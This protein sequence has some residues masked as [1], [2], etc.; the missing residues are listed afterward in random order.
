MK[1]KKFKFEHVVLIIE[2]IIIILAGAFFIFYLSDQTFISEIG[3]QTVFMISIGITVVNTIFCL[4]SL[5]IAGKRREKTDLKIGTIIGSDIKEA[6]L[7]AKVG[8]VVVNEEGYVLWTSDLFTARQINIIGRNIYEWIPNLRECLEKKDDDILKI[9]FNGMD[10]QVKFLKSAGLFIFKDVTE[11]E[12]LDKYSKDQSLCLG[13]IVI[14]NYLEFTSGTDENNDTVNEVRMIINNYFKKFD[15]LLRQ[16]KNDSYVLICN[17]ASLKKLRDDNFSIIDEVRQVKAKEIVKPTLSIGIA[18]DYLDINRLSEMATNSI[19]IAMSRGGDQVVISRFG[20]DLEFFGGKSEATVNGSRVKL[21]VVS[22]SL[23]NLVETASNVVI[24]GH[25]EADMDAIGSCLGLKAFCDAKNKDVK[26]VYDSKLCERKTKQAVSSMFSREE[27]ANIFV[28]PKQAEDLVDKKTLLIVTDVSRPS[29]TMAPKLLE[30]TDKIVIIDHHRRAQEFIEN[31]ILFYIEPG[32][33]SSS[34]IVAQMAKYNT[35]SSEIKINSIFATFMLSG[36]FLDSLNFKSKTTGQGT[37][38]ASMILKDFGA[39]IK[40][41][42]DLLKDDFEEY[43]LINKIITNSTV[44]A[45]GIRICKCEN[46]EIVET[47]TIAKAANRALSFKGMSCSF[48]VG[49][50]AEKE[51]KICARSDGSINVQILMEL[52]GGGGHHSMAAASIEET[53][54]EKVV[55]QINEVL[56]N[57]LD[58]AKKKDKGE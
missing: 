23:L 2:T 42:D 33:S 35:S 7:F 44:P 56:E 46:D 39:D 50:V 49:K 1:Q 31:T 53:E 57:H 34:E 18:Y 51:I 5:L 41:A 12:A 58:E 17:S 32:A 54:I 4:V 3:V 9:S 43:E 11:Y 45:Y 19:D 25:T 10:Y 24:M 52:L 21:R 26:V 36:I 27:I 8:L 48:V 14:D 22:D 6:Y 29:M 20:S 40:I 16:Y 28:T 13:N 15:C 37:F 55:D 47:A 38:E 30:N